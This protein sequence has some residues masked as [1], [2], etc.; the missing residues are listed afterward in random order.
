MIDQI[1]T[2]NSQLMGIKPKAA[3]ELEQNHVDFVVKAL[4]EEAQELEDTAQIEDPQMRLVKQI[5]AA[6]DASI[7]AIGLMARAGMTRTQAYE[8]F[9]AVHNANMQKKLGVTHR[10]DMGVPDAAKP[11]GWVGPEETMR[12]VLFPGGPQEQVEGGGTKAGLLEDGSFGG[13]V[14][15]DGS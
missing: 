2:F 5:D 10:G 8:C 3:P 9:S 11:A 7:F 13:F 12:Q 1:F 15:G 4:R 14:G 6:I